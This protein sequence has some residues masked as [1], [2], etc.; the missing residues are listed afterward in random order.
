MRRRSARPDHIYNWLADFFNN[1]YHCTV[2][3]GELSTL[4]DV[5]ASIQGS[6]IG[7]AAYVVTA[8]DLV[9]TVPG[10]SLCKYVII[11]AS[12]EASQL[13]GLDN[14]QRWT[15]QNDLK[16]NCSK[17]IEIVF[18]DNDDTPLQSRRH[19]LE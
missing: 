16:L 5:T 17:S 15:K 14:V 4:P 7:P 11:P 1:H 13:V 2:L 6:A 18:R 12:N 19:C 10:N 8:G 3:G 9:A